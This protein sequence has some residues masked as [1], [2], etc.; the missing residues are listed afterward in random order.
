M[1]MEIE[2]IRVFAR[3]IRRDVLTM[4]HRAGVNGGH[5]GGALSAADILA[6]LYGGGVLRNT[7]ERVASPTRDRF[8]LS[9]G[10]I[11]LA[12]YA[13]LDQAGFFP[14]EKLEEFE[15]PG[16]A[17]PTHE[18]RREEYGIE[19][20][21]GSLG[22]GLS[23]GIGC[24][25]AARM[26]GQDYHTYILMGDGECNEGSVWEASMAAARY[27]LSN[28]TAIVDVNGQSL[29]GRMDDIMPIHDFRL[30]FQSCGWNVITVDGHDITKIYDGLQTRVEDVPT[31]VLAMTQKGKGVASIEGAVGWHH[32]AL[33]D[34]Q[35][36][37]FI[38]ELE[39]MP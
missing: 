38:R 14:V 2:R 27:R 13:A 29:D 26:R 36:E 35:Y 12:H 4:T 6:V 3:R 15:Q 25:L 23:I 30:A 19:T 16:C 34:E 31:V 8:I 24:A 10:H 22:Y 17:F 32:A 37:K 9:K 18:V 28:L 7:P 39:D 33:S 5:I 21:S 11:A 20:S 1:M